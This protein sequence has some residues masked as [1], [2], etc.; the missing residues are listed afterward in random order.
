MFIASTISLNLVILSS[1][2]AIRV[3]GLSLRSVKNFS[4]SGSSVFIKLSVISEGSRL[5]KAIIWQTR[6]LVTPAFADRSS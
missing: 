4:V 1:S 5:H 3:K 2:V 6:A